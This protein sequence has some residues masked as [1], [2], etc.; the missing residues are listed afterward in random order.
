MLV[1]KAM[2]PRVSAGRVFSCS[3][4]GRSMYQPRVVAQ[5]TGLDVMVSPLRV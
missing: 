3:P 1:T 4:A 5:S 2:A